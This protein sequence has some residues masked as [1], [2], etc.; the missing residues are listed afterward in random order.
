MNSVQGYKGFITFLIL[1][2]LLIL[3][4]FGIQNLSQTNK[5]VNDDTKVVDD[6]SPDV[7]GIQKSKLNLHETDSEGIIQT[8][9]PTFN[10]GFNDFSDQDSVLGKSKDVAGDMMAGEFKEAIL[11]NDPNYDFN[12]DGLVT[13]ADWPLFIEFVT[14]PED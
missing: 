4:A 5:N 13:N 1:F 3:A 8:S 2:I 7:M 14:N 11:Y 6:S 9:Q 10:I 12:K